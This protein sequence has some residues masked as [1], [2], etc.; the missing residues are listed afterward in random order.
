MM[1]G[2]RIY[3]L[4]GCPLEFAAKLKLVGMADEDFAEKIAKVIELGGKTINDLIE[5]KK[6][7]DALVR[8]VEKQ[9]VVDMETLRAVAEAKENLKTRLL[10]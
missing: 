9:S 5:T 7:L 3:E 4:L 1:E 2:T 6:A 8:A 10:N